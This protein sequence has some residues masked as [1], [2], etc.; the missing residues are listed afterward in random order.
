MKTIS[1][2]KDFSLREIP[3]FTNSLLEEIVED[4][5]LL[6]GLSQ[7]SFLEKIVEDN[8]RQF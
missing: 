6:Q 2:L 8:F 7:E 5:F 4:N 3:I 1:P